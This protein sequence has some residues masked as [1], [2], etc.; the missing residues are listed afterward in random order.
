MGVG[1]APRG[2]RERPRQLLDSEEI[3]TATHVTLPARPPT[4]CAMALVSARRSPGV[5]DGRCRRSRI[6][7]LDRSPAAEV[8]R[9]TASMRAACWQAWPP[10][11]PAIDVYR[12]NGYASRD[13]GD[14]G[15]RDVRVVGEMLA[16]EVGVTE[17]AYLAGPALPDRVYDARAR[18][19]ACVYRRHAAP[20]DVVN[21]LDELLVVVGEPSDGHG[22]WHL[23]SPFPLLRVG[24][25]LSSDPSAWA[26]GSRCVSCTPGTRPQNARSASPLPFGT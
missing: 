2:Y 20:D 12:P 24:S 26:E 1:R 15:Q 7:P 16:L 9:G 14:V 22:V 18:P 17:G 11:L 5:P 19:V 8:L 6:S 3:M 23:R 21:A 10:T 13:V 25:R 4:R